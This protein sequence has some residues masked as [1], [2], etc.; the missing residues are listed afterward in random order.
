[1][2][3]ILEEIVPK[4]NYGDLILGIP[5][6]NE[7]H[8]VATK[9][10]YYII[11]RTVQEVN[12]PNKRLKLNSSYACNLTKMDSKYLVFSIDKRHYDLK[13]TFEKGPNNLYNYIPYLENDE[14]N[15]SPEPK[16]INKIYNW[17]L[18]MQKVYKY[19]ESTKE[20]NFLAVKD[21]WLNYINK[22]DR[23]ALVVTGKMQITHKKNEYDVIINFEM[24]FP[25]GYIQQNFPEYSCRI[26][27]ND[28]QGIKRS[29]GRNVSSFF[30]LIEAYLM[31]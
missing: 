30:A 25:E 17:L 3:T 21:F 5:Y 20:Q 16:F 24:S 1:M 23:Q 26:N 27:P 22:Y 15:N 9:L 18:F 6:H 12:D 29:V 11:K 14:F 19:P 8:N 4:L 7:Y 10:T 28:M 13:Y 31:K 2:D